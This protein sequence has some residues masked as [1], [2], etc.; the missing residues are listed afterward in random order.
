M[1]SHWVSY[2]NGVPM[3]EDTGRISMESGWPEALLFSSHF[4]NVSPWK[5]LAQ[6][7]AEEYILKQGF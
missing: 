1:L 7:Q 3:E 2:D 4:P 5:E 6:P